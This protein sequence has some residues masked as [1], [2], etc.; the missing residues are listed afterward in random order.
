MDTRVAVESTVEGSRFDDWARL[1]AAVLLLVVGVVI[2]VGILMGGNAQ[3]PQ[4]DLPDSKTDTALY[5][6][7][8]TRVQDGENYYT[9]AAIEQRE[10]GYPLRPALTMREPTLAYAAAAVGG[11]KHLRVINLL[12]GVAAGLVMVLKLEQISRNRMMWWAAA[13]LTAGSA[14][15]V[16]E[17]RFVVMHEAWAA[18]FIVC[19][20]LVRREGR[21]A[22]PSV[23]F[24]FLAVAVRELACPFI[25]V[26]ALLAW[27]E[28]KRR[29]FW[30]W[31][32]ASALFL[33][34]YSFHFG[35]VLSHTIG[36][37]TESQGWLKVGGWPFAL[38]TIRE[39]SPLSTVPF[40]VTAV[41]VPLALLGWASKRGPFSNRVFAVIASFL[42]IFMVIGRPENWYWGILYAP[43]VGAGIAFAPAAVLVLASR[44]RLPAKI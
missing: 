31:L 22:V 41:V 2:A 11:V 10:R 14:A 16:V 15:A 6:A 21:S 24:G 39:S 13:G 36:A 40:W 1:P 19:S 25:L 43:L 8:I 18:L 44:L 32:A 26:M 30:Q 33:I 7:I 35:L 23:V 42:V 17:P 27:S 5:E 28:G 4:A 34:G 3:V 12:L 20:L 29:E 37:D 9:A 38:G